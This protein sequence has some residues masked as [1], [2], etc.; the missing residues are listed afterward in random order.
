MNLRS[1]ITEL[2]KSSLP[3]YTAVVLDLRSRGKLL[4][5][6]EKATG[7]PLL[8]QHYAHHMT[9]Q[10]APTQRDMN[11]L[12]HTFGDKVSIQVI[13]W[14]GDDKAQAVVVRGIP[15]ASSI[16]HITVATGGGSSAYTHTLLD[17]GFERIRGPRLSG[18]IQGQARSE[19]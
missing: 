8:K 12:D 18:T 7:T 16:A 15:S 9:I 6:W 13:G 19:K 4:A 17:Q 11:R 2:R 14:A 3:A 1:L 5:W 10:F